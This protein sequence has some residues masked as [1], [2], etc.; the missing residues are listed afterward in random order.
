MGT[1]GPRSHDKPQAAWCRYSAMQ[2]I[3]DND[4]V[5]LDMDSLNRHGTW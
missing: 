3:T 5:W 4:G 2:A 1:L